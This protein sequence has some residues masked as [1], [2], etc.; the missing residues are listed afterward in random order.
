MQMVNHL[1]GHAEISK[2]HELFKN[3]KSL[4]NV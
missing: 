4:M 3:V 1:E 2:K